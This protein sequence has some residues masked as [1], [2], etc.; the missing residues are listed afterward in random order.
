MSCSGQLKVHASLVNATI[1]DD[2]SGV[3]YIEIKINHTVKGLKLEIVSLIFQNSFK[4]YSAIA[5]LSSFVYLII[6][7]PE[8]NTPG[9]NCKKVSAG[10]F[11]P[12]IMAA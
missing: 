12:S 4:K 10:V 1:T 9:F 7:I 3:K 11:L 6:S 8:D 5:C 2:V